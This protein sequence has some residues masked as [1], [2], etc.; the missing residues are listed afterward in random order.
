VVY[1]RAP[2]TDDVLTLLALHKAS[3]RLYRGVSSPMTTTRACA[4]Y[5]E[6]S[7]RPDYTGMLVCRTADDQIVAS[8]NISQIVRGGF[9]SAY[10]GYQAFSP[11][12]G[13][14]YMTAAMPLVLRVVF[15]HLHLHRVE[16]NIQPG[17]APSIALV[18]RAGFVNEGFSERYLKVAG[19]WR[20]HE[21]WAMTVERW[22]ALQ[23]V[24]RSRTTRPRPRRSPTATARRSQDIR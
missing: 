21:R 16:A 1:L 9:Q 11:Y 18:A 19:R 4:A 6:R 10:M 2:L 13:H 5:V 20:D 7:S 23:R 8:V 15:R 12:A 14:G 22:T 3:A 24:A 17:N